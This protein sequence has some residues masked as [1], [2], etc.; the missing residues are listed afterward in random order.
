M[1]DMRFGS[2]GAEE[3]DSRAM[4]AED[5]AQAERTPA[6]RRKDTPAGDFI[7]TSYSRSGNVWSLGVR[8]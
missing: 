3:Y 7:R 5:V 4:R 2:I 8:H 1:V 6:R